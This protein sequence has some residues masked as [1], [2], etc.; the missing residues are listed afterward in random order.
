MNSRLQPWVILFAVSL[1]GV[2]TALAQPIINVPG[3]PAPSNIGGTTIL[4]V[5]NGGLLGN[6]FTASGNSTVNLFDGG[7][8]RDQNVF[9]TNSEF[10]MFG[11]RVSGRLSTRENAIINMSGGTMNGNVTIS[12]GIM[13]MSGGDIQAAL[14]ISS[15]FNMTGGDAGPRTTVFPGGT[16]SIRGGTLGGLISRTNSS[17]SLFGSEFLLNSVPITGLNLIGNSVSF[18]LPA[19]G[20]FSGVLADG[21]PF[22]FSRFST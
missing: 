5:N 6:G 10:N 14:G 22:F 9:R 21:T 4:N 20:F 16:A 8:L 2:S 18:N 3:D 17:T 12:E 13:D 11:G 7:T 15:V 1:A 19:D